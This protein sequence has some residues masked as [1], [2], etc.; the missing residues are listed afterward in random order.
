MKKGVDKGGDSNVRLIQR[1]GK[2]HFVERTEERGR[3]RLQFCR[4]NMPL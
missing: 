1:A 3:G 4:S 2:F